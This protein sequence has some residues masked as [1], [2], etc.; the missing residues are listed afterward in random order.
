M[1]ESI[2]D[3]QTVVDIV[4]LIEARAE[5]RESGQVG[6]KRM[7]REQKKRVE[8]VLSGLSRYFADKVDSERA[9]IGPYT[10]ADDR[11]LSQ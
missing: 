4:R 3:L 5:T 1:S 2:S 11:A 9:P 10:I 6:K 8:A 7:G